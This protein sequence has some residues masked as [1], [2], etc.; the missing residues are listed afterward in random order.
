MATSLPVPPVLTLPSL[1]LETEL[2]RVES[3]EVVFH[4]VL[5][6]PASGVSSGSTLWHFVIQTASD[7]PKQDKKK[8]VGLLNGHK[9]TVLATAVLNN[10]DDH[11]C[12]IFRGSDQQALPVYFQFPPTRTLCQW[13]HLDGDLVATATL[14]PKTASGTLDGVRGQRYG[15]LSPGKRTGSKLPNPV[16][17]G[18]TGIAHQVHVFESEMLPVAT[19][20]H[21]LYKDRSNST[22]P[23]LEANEVVDKV[24]YRIDFSKVWLLGPLDA[25]GLP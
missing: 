5:T 15:Q 16:A 8:T 24:V 25:R 11:L 2:R 21:H 1:G 3:V 9:G 19:V 17:C 14:S 4:S 22:L 20:T 13:R 23:Y 12:A 7:P 10:D 18:Q 6:G